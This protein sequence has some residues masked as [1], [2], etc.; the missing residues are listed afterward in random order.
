MVPNGLADLSIRVFFSLISSFGPSC[1]PLCSPSSF[2][3]FPVLFLFYYTPI[4]YDMFP[5]PYS[6]ATN[7]RFSSRHLISKLRACSDLGL[8]LFSIPWPSN[9]NIRY[10]NLI[11]TYWLPATCI[12]AEDWLHV[13]L[14]ET[15]DLSE[16]E[17][18]LPKIDSVFFQAV[19][20][21]VWDFLQHGS[22]IGSG[23][24]VLYMDTKLA[25]EYQ[26]NAVCVELSTLQVHC[27]LFCFHFF[28]SLS[29][30]VGHPCTSNMHPP[31]PWIATE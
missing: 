20:Y 8:C 16:D 31:W 27:W 13:G 22:E 11:W 2:T 5:L 21:C 15:Q 10:S 3:L 14:S 25:P 12:H 7:F 24:M 23:R 9:L 26:W 29:L 4:C 1:Q 19:D 18:S 17:K 30:S 6:W 28:P